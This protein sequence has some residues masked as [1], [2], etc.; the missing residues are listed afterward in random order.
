MLTS[1]TTNYR[2]APSVQPAAERRGFT[3]VE[4]LVVVAIVAIMAT[5]AGALYMGTFKN[6][7]LEKA[8]K[9]FYL[10][11]KYARLGAVEKQTE[12]RLAIDQNEGRFFI[13]YEKMNPDTDE[14][15]NVVVSN[16]YTK[17]VTLP[18]GVRIEEITIVPSIE[19]IEP[20]NRGD[21]ESL[22]KDKD[23][24]PGTVIVF[25]PYGTADSAVI[26]IG[27]GKTSFTVSISPATGKV[28]IARGELEMQ[29][30]IID[31]DELQA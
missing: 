31:L 29:L 13:A 10:A 8:A 5:A 22:K 11:A 7:Q 16:P 15:E 18:A 6:M 4:I 21:Q 2:P 25:T 28:K 23:R 24:E 30:D 3:M 9:E 19:M 27:N 1:L 26:K 17:P 14:L 20:E 12:F